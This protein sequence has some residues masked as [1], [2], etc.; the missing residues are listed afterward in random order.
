M[1]TRWMRFDIKRAIGTSLLAIAILAIPGTI[2]HAL[3]GHIDWRIALVLALGVIP[4]ALI[5]ARLSLGAAE[6]T[7]RLAF[8]AMLVV[9]GAWLAISELGLD[10]VAA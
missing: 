10:G 3:L 5:G 9:V 4:G 7:I 1:L 8:A 6:R 2:T